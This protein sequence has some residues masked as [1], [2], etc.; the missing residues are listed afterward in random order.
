MNYMMIMVTMNR[1]RLTDCQAREGE[2][3]INSLCVLV[4]A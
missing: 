3:E 4:I 2:I 1:M